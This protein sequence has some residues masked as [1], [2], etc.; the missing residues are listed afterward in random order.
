MLARRA[1]QTDAGLSMLKKWQTHP[2]PHCANQF[3]QIIQAV[4]S[5][6]N[7]QGYMGPSDDLCE[8]PERLESVLFL[9]LMTDQQTVQSNY[10]IKNRPSEGFNFCSI[11]FNCNSCTLKWCGHEW[12]NYR[13]GLCNHSQFSLSDANELW[14]LGVGWFLLFW[15]WFFIT[16]KI[17][18]NSDILLGLVLSEFLCLFLQIENKFRMIY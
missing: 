13:D 18:F 6:K 15:T 12:T 5:R 3:N 14:L 9:G 17:R 4:G 1:S 16:C 2:F 10:C 11:I 7:I 8:E